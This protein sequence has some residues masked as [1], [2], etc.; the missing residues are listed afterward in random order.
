[1]N[2]VVD[3]IVSVA[4][5]KPL[6]IR[7]LVIGTAAANIVMT[8]L[9]LHRL[10]LGFN[11]RLEG[12]Q[13]LMITARILVATVIMAALGYGV[14]YVVDAVV[15]RSLP[16]QI[17]AVGLGCTAAC[18]LYAKLVLVMRIPEAQQIEM[19]IRARL[20]RASAGRRRDRLKAR[21]SSSSRPC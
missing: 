18:V 11:G 10:R 2:M 12:G 8:Y 21:R 16:G 14:W 5:Y 17:I 1:M 20:G 7:G 6:G 4:L 13:T 9:Q 3:V 15:G 19:L